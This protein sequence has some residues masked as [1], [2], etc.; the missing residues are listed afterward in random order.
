MT[1]DNTLVKLS[2]D[3]VEI[4]AQDIPGWLVAN[5]GKNTVALDVTVTPKLEKEGL[6]R[7]FINRIQNLRKQSGLEVNDHIDLTLLSNERMNEAITEHLDYI[8]KQIQADNIVIS[9][10]ISDATEIE[11]EDMMLSVV[12]VK[13]NN[14]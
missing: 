3:D 8:S 9:D 13:S 1:I 10:V 11:I 5:E 2:T 12:L 7:E 6:A 4:I 14:Q